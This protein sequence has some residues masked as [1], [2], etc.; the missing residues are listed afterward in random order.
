MRRLDALRLAAIGQRAVG[1]REVGIEPRLEAEIAH[2]LRGL[3]PAEAGLDAAARVERAVEHAEIRV[4]AAGRLQQI[5]RLGQPDA[6]LDL[7][8]R[9]GEAAGARERDAQRVVGLRAR[10]GGLARALGV[11]GGA[12]ARAA[13]ASARSAQAMA[14]ALSPARNASRP[15]SWN[16]CARSIGIAV[17][18]EPLETRGEAGPGAL[19]IAGFPVQSADLALQARGAGAIRR[20]LELLAHRLV[21]RESL[22]PP[23]GERQQIGEPLAHGPASGRRRPGSSA[24]VR[25]A[26]S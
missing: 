7:L 19:A 20:G 21:V 10:C 24:S 11:G 6:L 23:P 1:H 26:R 4:A 18:A 25:S 22:G 5:V 15:I 8:D 2:L 16:S 14:P 12:S 9:L 17:L 13:S 3:E